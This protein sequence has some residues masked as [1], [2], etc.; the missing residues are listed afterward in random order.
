MLDVKAG[1]NYSVTVAVSG[2]VMIKQLGIQFLLQER[3][4]TTVPLVSSGVV[5]GLLLFPKSEDGR[6]SL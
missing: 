1:G 6:G 2:G 3:T 4:Q 5:G